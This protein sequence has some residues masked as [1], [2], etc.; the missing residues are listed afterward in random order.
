MEICSMNVDAR[1]RRLNETG[2]GA[3][4]M[5]IQKSFGVVL[6]CKKK[7]AELFE[8]GHEQKAPFSL[9]L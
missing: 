4:A 5:I 3:N 6:F 9:E 2:M 8:S 7:K 1:Q